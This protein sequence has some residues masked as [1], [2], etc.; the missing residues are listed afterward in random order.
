MEHAS[1]GLDSGHER[2]GGVYQRFSGAESFALS[3]R[4]LPCLLQRLS[5]DDESDDGDYEGEHRRDCGQGRRNG[6]DESLGSRAHL[7]VMRVA[8]T[9]ARA[10]L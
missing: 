5:C 2:P 10:E 8:S 1:R 3:L 9:G 7:S 6:G 4:R